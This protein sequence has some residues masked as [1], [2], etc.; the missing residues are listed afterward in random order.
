MSS[1]VEF[2]VCPRVIFQDVGER[3]DKDEARMLNQKEGVLVGN[4]IHKSTSI[5][6]WERR[7]SCTLRRCGFARRSDVGAD[8]IPSA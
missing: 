4:R 8:L 3:A 5:N 6:R 2:S 7:A 1:L